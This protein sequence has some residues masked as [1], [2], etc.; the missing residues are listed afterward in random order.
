MSTITIIIMSIWAVVLVPAWYFGLY[1]NKKVYK[2]R[3]SLLRK[4]CDLPRFSSTM[5]VEEMEAYTK[6]WS[7]RLAIYQVW[8]YD[9]MVYSFKPL[10]VDAWFGTSHDFDFLR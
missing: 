10:T 6:E 8:D 7:R 5:T 1:R 4:M 3:H 2:F 9:D